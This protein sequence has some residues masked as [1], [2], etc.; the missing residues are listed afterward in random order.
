MSKTRHLNYFLFFGLAILAVV[1]AAPIE[2]RAKIALCPDFSSALKDES[3]EYRATL[4]AARDALNQPLG[5][6]IRETAQILKDKTA[7][8]KWLAGKEMKAYREGT[9]VAAKNDGTISRAAIEADQ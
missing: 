6:I 4:A 9:E 8:F 7:L 1:C 5:G 3:P 2:Q